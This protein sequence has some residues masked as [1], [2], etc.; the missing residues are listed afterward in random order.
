MRLTEFQFRHF[1]NDSLE[2]RLSMPRYILAFGANCRGTFGE[3]AA[4]L[5]A[6]IEILQRLGFQIER[7]S[8]MHETAPVSRLRQP[9]YA[10]AAALVSIALPPAQILRITKALE[11]RAGRVRVRSHGAR[12][13]DVDIID[14]GGRRIGWNGPRRS[15]RAISRDRVARTGRPHLVVPHPLAH[16]RAFVLDPIA[17]IAPHWRHVGLG[18]TLSQ[19]RARLPRA[20]GVIRRIG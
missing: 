14:A 17:D 4:S 12:P 20:P 15:A 9:R 7:L 3:P 2:V 8:A 16:G 13:L 6:A 10:N 19:L 5:K 11:R 18:R 1:R